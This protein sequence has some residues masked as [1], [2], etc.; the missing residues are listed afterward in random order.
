MNHLLSPN[1]VIAGAKYESPEAAGIP[2][3]DC[4]V[5][6][7]IA[8][9]QLVYLVANTHTKKVVLLQP[10]QFSRISSVH[11]W[12]KSVDEV[13]ASDPW[14]HKEVAIKR[15]GVFS[16]SFTLVPA[17]FDHENARRT[18]L[19]ANCTVDEE[20][21][22]HADIVA[23]GSIHLLYALS[24]EI[25]Q[26]FSGKAGQRLTHALSGLINY[27]LSIHQAAESE[28]LYVYVQASSF[29]L[30][31]ISN[32][33]LH[34]CNSFNY[35]SPEDFLY[36]L[37]FTCK[38]LRLDPELVP[39][40]IMG[41]MMRESAMYQLLIKYIR[42]VQFARSVDTMKFNKDYPLPPHFFFNLF[43]L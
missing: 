18:I 33:S 39:L 42:N 25:V 10:Y 27:L 36:H 24:P 43:F 1:K 17:D 15:T 21:V 8:P 5:N 2:D 16:T 37:L 12:H 23:G 26:H 6:V 31:L 19:K 29:Q 32:K 4:E 30:L 9:A 14:L 3:A 38:Q 13:F 41:E 11:E 35:Y 22:V 20:S 34:Y 40:T 28:N 7:L